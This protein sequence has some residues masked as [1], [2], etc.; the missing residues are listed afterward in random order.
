MSE[1]L[2]KKWVESFFIEKVQ[3]LSSTGKRLIGAAI[4]EYFYVFYKEYTIMYELS[5]LQDQIQQ[6][7]S[8]IWNNITS[9]NN[10]KQLNEDDFLIETLNEDEVVETNAM[11]AIVGIFNVLDFIVSSEDNHLRNA[12][13]HITMT[14]DM[15]YARNENKFGKSLNSLE[16]SEKILKEPIKQYLED[17]TAKVNLEITTESIT[18]LQN[19]SKEFLI[20]F[21]KL[22][23]EVFAI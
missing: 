5:S 14:L 22:I 13:L 2:S 1:I 8:S 4:S 20:N 15:L 16:E 10:V 21:D 18:L 6:T 17:L 12:L 7:I 19:E 23:L 3:K 11:Y 9:P